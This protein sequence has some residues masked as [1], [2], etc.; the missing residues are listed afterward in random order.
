MPELNNLIEL[1][2]SYNE[3]DGFNSYHGLSSLK[4][5][6][7]GDNQLERAF[8]LK[9]NFTNLKE[10]YLDYSIN[11]D[12]NFLQSLG[13]MMPSVKLL[14]LRWLNGSVPTG[15][16]LN[17]KNLE[18][19][20]LSYSAINNSFGLQ[21][22]GIMRHLKTL[23]LPGCRLTRP[24]PTDQG[25]CKLK[26]LQELDISGN[27]LNGSL[28]WCLANLTSLKIFSLSSNN[29]IGD[30]ASSP[31]RR[32]TSLEYLDLSDN[33]FQIPIS[34]S[35]FFNHSNLNFLDCQNNTIYAI[36]EAHN[37]TPKFQLETLHL[38]GHGY[39][40]VEIPN[41][42]YH[43]YNLQYVDLSNNNIRGEFPF[44]LLGNNTK[45]RVIHLANN[46]L[47][48]P[49]QLPIHSP[50]NLSFLDISENSLYGSIPKKI[51]TH[52]SRLE[53]LNLKGNG[54]NGNIPPSFGNMSF[55]E[56]LDLSDNRLSG[57]IPEQLIVGCISLFQL[58]L[59]KNTL[60]GS[61]SDVFNGN[62]S[63]RS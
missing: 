53:I 17:F 28:P 56:S 30:I 16:L 63:V 31:L 4:K 24:I 40:S 57:S 39:G 9:G 59:S 7:I 29:F 61:L 35:L 5:L 49:F 13:A 54:L 37:F 10:L 44:W 47:L 46:S 62:S 55:L 50:P 22:I 45:L 11:V 27:Y 6:H 12:D 8:D 34:L 58:K 2:I 51:G 20:D 25:L 18:Y 26:F 1:D 60:Q 52:L 48:G 36:T 23:L 38:S 32:L 15:G 33:L 42:L 43:Q 41:F 14:S 3:I 21:D 19:L